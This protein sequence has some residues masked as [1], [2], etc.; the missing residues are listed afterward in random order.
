MIWARAPHHE[1]S[2]GGPGFQRMNGI[3]AGGPGL[4]A[5]GYDQLSETG[6]IDAVAVVWTSTDGVDWMRHRVD[7][8]EGVPGFRGMSGVVSFGAE[9]V[10]VGSDDTGGDSEAAVWTSPDGARWTRLTD[11]EAVF[12]GPGSQAMG[13]VVSAGSLLIAIGWDDS[14]GNHDAAVWLGVP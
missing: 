13:G 6:R 1:A 4:V 11:D 5:V 9:L 2:L 7:E 12:G 3:A 10:A 14:T 8:S